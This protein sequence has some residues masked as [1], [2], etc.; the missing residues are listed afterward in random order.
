MK[1]PSSKDLKWAHDIKKKHWEYEGHHVLHA[2][3]KGLDLFKHS[4]GRAVGL[5]GKGFHWASKHS[6]YLA[7]DFEKISHGAK[8]VG[9]KVEKFADSKALALVGLGFT[10]YDDFKDTRS[11][12]KATAK[13]IATTG[14]DIVLDGIID[15]GTTAI[16][17]FFGGPV[18]SVAGVT[19]GVVAD[20][21]VDKFVNNK[22]NQF[23]DK[24]F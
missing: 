4:Y 24:D 3:D 6:S 11:K 15:T 16:E 20:T 13:V 8:Y 18:G 5:V 22:I 7:S 19:T 1:T 12:I 9:G 23:I 14:T 2:T 10:A 17:G 21:V